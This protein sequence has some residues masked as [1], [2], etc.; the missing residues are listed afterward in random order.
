MLDP[1]HATRFQRLADALGARVRIVVEKDS[2]RA[3]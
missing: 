1:R 2:R 3:A